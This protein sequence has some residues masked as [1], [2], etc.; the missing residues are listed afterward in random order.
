MRERKGSRVLMNTLLMT[1]YLLTLVIEPAPRVPVL[2]LDDDVTDGPPA[3]ES[4]FDYP[5][6]D[7]YV[8]FP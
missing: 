7:P 5:Y 2:D 4:P 1:C 3:D 8:D 6:G